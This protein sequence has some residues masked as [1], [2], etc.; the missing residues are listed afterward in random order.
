[1]ALS[2]VAQAQTQTEDETKQ[3]LTLGVFA[4]LGEARTRDKFEPIVD[5][6]NS[7]LVKERIELLV[8]SQQALSDRIITGEVD[9]VLT[10]PTHFLVVRKNAPLSG[11]VATLVESS[12]GQP[13]H[14]LGGAIIVKADRQDLQHLGDLRH[15][16][17]AIPGFENMGGYRA[18]AYELHQA[19]VNVSRDLKRV[20]P[21]GSH[22]A[23]VQAVLSGSVDVGFI[24]D[25]ILEEMSDSGW[26]DMADLRLINEQTSLDFPHRVS[27]RLYP[28][29]PVFALAHVSESALRHF[30]SAL[31]SLEPDDPAAQKAGIQGFTV[32]A[33]YLAVEDL[34][35]SL[36]LAPYDNSPDF[37][38]A[39]V[40]ERWGNVLLMLLFGLT[41]VLLLSLT[42]IWVLKREKEE[43]QRFELLLSTL[44]EGVYGTDNKGLCTFVNPAAL[45]ML[46]LKQ[47]SDILGKNQHQLF[48]HHRPNGEAYPQTACPIHLTSIDGQ[49]RR[50]EEWFYRANGQG[51]PVDLIVTPLKK[52]GQV[53]GSVVV[54]QDSSERKKTQQQLIE[55]ATK[56]GLTGL[57][58]RRSLL[59]AIDKEQARMKRNTHS[60]CL[61]MMDLDY[62]KRVNDTYGH[63]A[64]DQVLI[65][66][67]DLIHRVLRESDLAGRF[68]GEEFVVLL[69]ETDLSQAQVVAER[70]RH[71]LESSSILYKEQR[72]EV[73]VSIGVT[74]LLATDKV[75]TAIARADKALY[76]AKEAGR[77]QVV[78]AQA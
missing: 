15:Q 33:D 75:E 13:V 41:L 16:V 30:A 77:N 73:T 57:D 6:L 18:Q 28:E 62:F 1:M 72:L 56:D 39:D 23:V 24:R 49:K 69:A 48:H 47:A 44:G 71:A 32:P 29:W 59:E 58:N 31:Y 50:V 3:V 78:V 53:I 25:G 63:A 21:F 5:Y 35:R 40:W 64:G 55:L 36:R 8:L 12:G 2:F 4:F 65:H 38:L 11:V 42:L 60:A 14:Q 61:L 27:T 54:F 7:R 10:N 43:H 22:Q 20:I 67:S 74:E 51:F 34:A 76:Q 19:G 68:G 26:L 17:V 9:L 45:K 52:D 66:F 37:T 46:G 70:L